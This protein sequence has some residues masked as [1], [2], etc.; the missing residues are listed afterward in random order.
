MALLSSSAC[1][2]G[3]T[4]SMARLDGPP[5][6]SCH[7]GASALVV[8]FIFLIFG[9]CVSVRHDHIVGELVVG[10]EGHTVPPLHPPHL[11]SLVVNTAGLDVQ[12]EL[13]K[14]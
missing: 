2:D 7:F 9:R 3:L 12:Y 5:A 13:A 14:K 11:V 10:P 8:F 6:F 1:F 4:G